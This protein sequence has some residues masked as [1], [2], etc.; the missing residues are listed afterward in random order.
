MKLRQ[1]EHHA[2]FQRRA[3]AIVQRDC[4]QRERQARIVGRFG[5][6]GVE[7]LNRALQRQFGVAQQGAS[8][9]IG[10]FEAQRAHAGQPCQ[11]LRRAV[12]GVQLQARDALQHAQARPLAMRLHAQQ[13]VRPR[14]TPAPMR[15]AHQLPVY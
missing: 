7:R 5:N 1:H 14:R 4:Q 11:R 6:Q 13:Q 10:C 3:A 12:V 2:C 9:G 8:E 15:T